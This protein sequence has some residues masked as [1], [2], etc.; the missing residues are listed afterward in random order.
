MYVYIYVY[1]YVYIYF[2]I[3]T[4]THT[5]IYKHV[6]IHI[7]YNIIC[8]NICICIYIYIY[9]YIYINTYILTNTYMYIW[10]DGPCLYAFDHTGT[11]FCSK[12]SKI[13]IGHS[14]SNFPYTYILNRII[15]LDVSDSTIRYPPF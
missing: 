9:I 4:C 5:Y 14:N 6:H 2:C 13:R 11:Y 7:I 3:H 10:E 8:I 12:L 15:V 1:T